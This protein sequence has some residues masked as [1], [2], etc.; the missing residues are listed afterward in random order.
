MKAPTNRTRKP[1]CDL[2]PIDFAT[3]PLWEYVL[4]EGAFDET[5][6]RPV[7]RPAIPDNGE[8][9]FVAVDLCSARGVLRPGCVEFFQN[10]Y[11][12]PGTFLKEELCDLEPRG[13]ETHLKVHGV[14]NPQIERAWV[15]RLEEVF[16]APFAE[17]F[18][19]RWRLRVPHASKGRSSSGTVTYIA[20][21][22]CEWAEDGA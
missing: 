18:P 2:T 14:L 19:M 10:A 16:G 13:S 17:I 15:K 8:L 1:A 20:H 3:F 4:D 11:R 12:F 6:V 21:K 22:S 5:Y 9:F 7:L